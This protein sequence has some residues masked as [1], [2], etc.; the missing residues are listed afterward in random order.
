MGEPG[1]RCATLAAVTDPER[2][3][4][5]AEHGREIA[6][7]A[8]LAPERRAIASEHGDLTFAELDRDAE[9]LAGYLQNAGLAAGDVVALLCTNRPEWIVTQQAALR[10][11]LRLVP[12][13]WHLKGDDIAYVIADSGAQALITED[14]FVSELSVSELSVDELGDETRDI[15]T[16]IVIGDHFEGFTSFAEALSQLLPTDPQRLRGSLMIYTSGSTGRP[17]GVRQADGST[18]SGAAIGAAMVAMFGLDGDRGDQMLCPAPLYHSGPSRICSEWPL[19]AGVTV[20]LM[21]RFDPEVALELIDTQRLTH[22]FFVPTMFHRMLGVTDRTR[23]D[24]SSLRFVLHGAGP[25]SAT[26]KQQ[27]FDWLGPIIHEMYAAAEGP[28]TWIQPQEWLEH[29]G[30]VGRT[31]PTRLQIRLDDGE[32]AKPLQDGTVWSRATTPFHYHD[33]PDKT[34]ATFDASGE[35]YTVGDRGYIDAEG[36]LYLTGR[37]AECIVSGGVNLYPARV[38]EALVGHPGVHDGAAFALSDVEFGQVMAAAIIPVDNTP[39]ND[40]IESVITHCRE[41]IGSQLTPRHVFI[42][43]ELPRT[44][45]G[46][47]Y[48]HRLT[49]QFSCPPT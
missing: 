41:T 45:A 9:R 3:I 23:Y 1:A 17:K 4:G 10:S 5:A 29:P 42:V 22:A 7:V 40:L 44:E 25:C 19:G 13:N 28:G 38:D 2:E 47:L 36:Y 49:E 33:D 16:R 26:I 15:K 30:S 37:T 21:A 48:R 39:N 11:G 18:S 46:K 43:D 34:A 8:R 24:L 6:M 27:M 20:H 32:V 12:V 35:W 14:T 31:D